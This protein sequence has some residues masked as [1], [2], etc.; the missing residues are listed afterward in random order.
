M[1]RQA[2]SQVIEHRF[3]LQDAERAVVLPLVEDVGELTKQALFLSQVTTYGAL[4]LGAA[5]LIYVPQLWAHVKEQEGGF[6]LPNRTF[7]ERFKWVLKWTPAGILTDLTLDLLGIEDNLFGGRSDDGS[8]PA[9]WEMLRDLTNPRGS[10]GYTGPTGP[11]GGG[12][13]F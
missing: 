11:S 12:G 1:P 10:D 6:G 13:G 8:N 4:G 2:P 3:S 7:G 9:W 5:T